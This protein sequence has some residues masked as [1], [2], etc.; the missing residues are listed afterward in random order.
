MSKLTCEDVIQQLYA[1]L[2]GELDASCE[3]DVDDHLHKCQE[4]LGRAEFERRLREKIRNGDPIDAPPALRN[5][6]MSFLKE[7]D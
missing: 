2:D 4:C 1:Y 5:K 6:L 7:A 3:F